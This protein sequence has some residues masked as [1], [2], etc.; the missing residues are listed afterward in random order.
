MIYIT[1]D[2]H[3]NFQRFFRKRIPYHLTK[4]DYIIVCGD[5]G[6]LW[7]K[8]KT[9]QYNLEVFKQRPYTILWVSGN[10]ENYNM[11]EEYP[12]EFWHGGLVRHIIRDK[13]ILLERGQ[14]FE[15]EGKKFFTFGGASSHDIQGG[16]LDINDPE[17]DEK[18]KRANRSYLP[19]RVKNISWWEAELPT[20]DE[21]LAG[22]ENLEKVN[23]QVDYV[24]THCASN[25]VQDK[26]EARYYG[27][28]GRSY[29]SDILTGY[30]EE[31]EE[32][33]QYEHWFCGHYHINEE[34]DS[35]HTVLYEKI[36]PLSRYDGKS[37]LEEC[38]GKPMYKITLYDKNC[39]PICDGVAR[40]FVDRLEE[41]E[42]PWMSKKSI[43]EEKKI[44]FQRSKNGEIVTDYY[45]DDAE[46]NIVQ[47]D[48]CA[49]VYWEKEFS[50]EK[51]SFVT[52]NV[53]DS[54]TEIYAEH[55]DITL[56]FVRFGAENFLIGK[57]KLQGVCQKEKLWE[58]DGESWTACSVWGNP[59]H[60]QKRKKEVFWKGKDG[61]NRYDYPKEHFAE[62]SVETYCWVIVGLYGTKMIE[63][64]DE[65][66]DEMI[67]C[68]L[69]DIPGEAG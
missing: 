5:F 30:F 50:Y 56:R 6:L 42:I 4:D 55:A 13:V 46:Y 43:D 24:I 18:R 3:A 36:V 29:F 69:K 2:T 25:R 40:F 54:S 23:Y 33:L 59:I 28:Y 37:I 63:A 19:Y 35:K 8:N 66:T 17:F 51:Q 10:H 68:L 44:R 7:A 39:C 15:I 20:E 34:I 11:I 22:K 65:L 21:M 9:F 14:V 32:K 27:D 58:E 52:Y 38:E 61:L 26:I 12:K 48:D 57:Y 60:I 47:R 49:K 31:I 53:Y 16:I 1:G 45:T 62:D 67:A 64:P 41:F